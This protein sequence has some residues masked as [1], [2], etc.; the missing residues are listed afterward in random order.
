MADLNAWTV[1]AYNIAKENGIAQTQIFSESMRGL[2]A[3]EGELPGYGDSLAVD[4]HQY[5]LF[6][7]ALLG[8]KHVDRISFACKNYKDQVSQ[9][10]RGFGPTMAGEWSQADTDCTKY[11]NGVGM[12][13]RWE[14][15]FDNGDG[16]K[17]ACPTLDGQCSCT[18][19]NADPSTWTPDYKLF[20]K[21]F[22]EAQMSAFE[23]SWGWFYWTWKTETAPQWS[24]QAAIQG[25]FMP[26]VA[27][28]RDFSCDK[29]IPSFG[30]LPEF[31]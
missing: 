4:V 11:L 6:D 28:E 15:K 14:G 24:Y 21:T 7:N 8:L 13:A 18:V 12:G 9:S 29:P 27:Y 31:Y 20:L 30:S 3:W 10:M 17:V 16:G 2:S 5:T 25:D 22:A 26:K 1:K 23:S 19:P